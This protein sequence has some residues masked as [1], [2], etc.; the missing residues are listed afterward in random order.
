[1]L[2]HAF[3]ETLLLFDGAPKGSDLTLLL[4][5]PCARRLRWTHQGQYVEIVSNPVPI[6]WLLF[7]LIGIGLL[8]VVAPFAVVMGGGPFL[9]WWRWLMLGAFTG[10]VA[11]PCLLL[12]SAFLLQRFHSGE[13]IALIDTETREL[14]LPACDRPLAGEKIFQFIELFRWFRL[15]KEWRSVLQWSVVVQHPDGHFEVYPIVTQH[16]TPRSASSA[17]IDRLATLFPAPLLRIQLDLPQSQA[18]SEGG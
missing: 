14:H 18:L 1:M 6:A 7:G 8:V 17:T 12:L 9:G 10:L 15:E 2:P 13:V 4:K 11:I 3:T 5:G 16:Q